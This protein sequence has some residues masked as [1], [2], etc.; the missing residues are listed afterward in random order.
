MLFLEKMFKKTYGL[1]KKKHM[2]G[3]VGPHKYLF[4]KSMFVSH[5]VLE[6]KFVA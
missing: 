6:S 5:L 2:R 3:L 4:K 1:Q